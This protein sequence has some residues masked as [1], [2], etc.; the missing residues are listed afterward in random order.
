MK[1]SQIRQIN[2]ISE[3]HQIRGLP[4]PEH[5]LISLVDYRLIKYALDENPVTWVQDFYTIGLKRDVCGKFRYGQQEYDFDEGLMSFIAPGQV[6]SFEIHERD[7]TEP[8]S[9]GWLLLVHPDFLWNTAL[10]R[11]IKHYGFFGYAVNEALFLSEK[12]EAIILGIMQGIQQE[13]HAN[14]DEFSQ[15]IIVSQIEL[16]LNYAD[17]FYHRQFITRKRNNHKTLDRLEELLADYFNS[18]DLVEKGLPSV[19]DISDALNM[20]ANY[21]SSLLKSLTGQSTQ[22]HI[23]NKLIER[24]KEKLSTSNLSVSEI[25]YTLGFE[26]P[27]SFSKLFKNKT[28]QTPLEFSQSFN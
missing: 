28:G 17:R 6:Y 26:H 16:L 4:K 3:F 15:G 14:I 23:H 10:A 1:S 8:Q 20:S 13:Y 9:S 12:E 7:E 22:Q 18:N 24:A 19:Q 11:Q 5:P 21:L 25:A 2:T 27:Q